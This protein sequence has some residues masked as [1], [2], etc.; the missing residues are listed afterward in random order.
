MDA[1]DESDKIVAL[2]EIAK[3]RLSSKQFEIFAQKHESQITV[4]TAAAGSGKTRLL[5]FVV[6]AALLDHSID[7]VFMMTT[8]RA[9]KMEA[10]QRCMDLQ[11]EL[12]ENM[13]LRPL[14]NT[15]VRTIHSIALLWARRRFEDQSVEIASKSVI[16]AILRDLV[17]LEKTKADSDDTDDADDADD[18]ADAKDVD[19]VDDELTAVQIGARDLIAN[20]DT[21]AAVELLYNIRSERLKALRPVVDGSLGPTA[22][23]V[24]NELERRMM[25]DD[26]GPVLVDF[27]QL[28]YLLALSGDA[29]VRN[30]ELMFID[31]FQDLSRSQ[32]AI[33]MNAVNAGARVVALGDASQGI[34]GFSGAMPN[35]FKALF[36]LADEA[37]IEVEKHELFQNH[38]STDAIVGASEGFLS[39]EDRVGREGIVGNGKPSVPVKFMTSDYEPVWVAREIVR[40]VKE[41]ERT[42]GEIVVLR[43]KNF[44]PDDPFVM[45]LTKEAAL[46][47]VDVKH[48]ISGMDPA[49][50]ITVKACAIL[51]VA[52]GIEHFVESPD[53]AIHL[54]KG[55][56]KALRGASVDLSMASKAIELV[57]NEKKC[58]PLELFTTHES[59]LAKAFLK[60]LL[61]AEAKQAAASA[62][63]PPPKR[64][65]KTGRESQKFKNFTAAVHKIAVSMNA[66]TKRLRQ[67]FEEKR[68]LTRL[69]SEKCPIAK[70]NEP[71]IKTALG[72]LAW[73]IV[74]DLVDHKFTELDMDEIH[75]FV[76]RFEQKGFETFE[77]DFLDAVVS[78]TSTLLT[79]RMNVE[80]EKKVVFST[81][82]KFKGLERNVVFSVN[83]KEAWSKTSWAQRSTLAHSHN[84]GCTNLSGENAKCSCVTFLNDVANLCDAAIS[85]KRRLLYVAA[86]RAREDLYL[87]STQ[88]DV[89]PSCFECAPKAR[90]ERN[91]W[92]KAK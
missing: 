73:L 46:L 60:L 44:R 9:A 57:W 24:L 17:S 6:S 11:I 92:H 5:T 12:G 78:T 77:G 35:T 50:S 15:N 30:R 28:V 74:S 31:E 67:T 8:T 40:L 22:K 23:R 52:V 88:T 70:H 69:S 34:F 18:K 66:L 76:E 65:K 55:F 10:H 47:K 33:V 51:R 54:V 58:T 72:G 13:A 81:I 4:I 41:K 89:Q 49:N 36:E 16:T 80:S 87:S 20:L 64:A 61:E 75:A 71:R 86:S 39:E 91:F 19:D 7:D 25:G 85:E 59:A 2:F 37:G 82:H 56:I 90:F 26:E 38:R 1:P 32:L 84:E 3:D 14:K 79:E 43:H 42:P 29:I 48:V 62:G 83:I 21:S 45:A 63:Q 27:D 53:D 68:P